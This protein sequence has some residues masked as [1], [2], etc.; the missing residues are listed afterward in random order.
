MCTCMY[1]CAY[2][3][4]YVHTVYTCMYYDTN[5]S[6]DLQLNEMESRYMEETT[7]LNS[8]LS[9]LGVKIQKMAFEYQK[10]LEDQYLKMEVSF[11]LKR[12]CMLATYV[13]T[14]V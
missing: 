1:V 9:M 3:R 12:F 5:K 6:N 13:C 2:V 11:G 7:E 10:K 14:Q 4:I 8:Q